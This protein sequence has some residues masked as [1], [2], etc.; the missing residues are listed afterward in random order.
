MEYLQNLN[1][2][3]CKS[4]GLNKVLL[5]RKL[6][7]HYKHIMTDIFVRK[8]INIYNMLQIVDIKFDYYIEYLTNYLRRIYKIP[9]DISVLSTDVVDIE[10]SNFLNLYGFFMIKLQL[11]L[12]R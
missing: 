11:L 8:K 10:K 12:T 4:T 9:R 2:T 3:Y 7:I 6:T 1:N 5:T